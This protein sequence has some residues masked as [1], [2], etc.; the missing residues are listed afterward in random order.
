[1]KERSELEEK[2]LSRLQELSNILTHCSQQTAVTSSENPPSMSPL[3]LAKV[4]DLLLLKYPLEYKMLEL[5]EIGYSFL[6][7]FL[8]REI[9]SKWDPL[10]HPARFLDIYKEWQRLF[11][12][13]KELEGT[14]VLRGGRNPSVSCP[15]GTIFFRFV[16][17]LVYEKFRSFIV[18]DWVVKSPSNPCHLFEIWFDIFP[19]ALTASILQQYVLPKLERTVEGWNPRQEAIPID[20]WLHPWI[21][22]LGDSLQSLYPTIRHKISEVLSIWHPSDLTAHTILLPWKNVFDRQSL[23]VL[24]VRSVIPKLAMCLRDFIINPVNQD[25]QPLKWV[26]LWEDLLPSNVFAMLFV[27]EFFPKWHQ[28][29]CAWLSNQPNYD[30]V[31]RWYSGWKKQF[32]ADLKSKDVIRAQFNHALQLME[33]SLSGSQTIHYAPPPTTPAP[34]PGPP[35]PPSPPSDEEPEPPPPPPKTSLAFE[36]YN[37]KMSFKQVVEKFAEDHDTVFM[38][39]PRRLH[40]GKQVY[41]FGNCLVLIDQQMLLRQSE[42][43]WVPVSLNELLNYK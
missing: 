5:S 34:P 8:K 4:F 10:V 39:V 43:K 13:G 19:R 14:A 17:D 20:V 7:P 27:N 24:L 30:E 21:P 6:Y 36:K 32:S 1:M 12:Q 35:P 42:G 33:Q 18:N 15:G 11:E 41:S 26:M 9:L 38:P 23:D 31:S 37:L 16:R 2:E 3:A 25:L 28:V 29:L 22:F 40:E